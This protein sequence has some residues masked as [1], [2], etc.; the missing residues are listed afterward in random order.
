VILGGGQTKHLIALPLGVSLGNNA[1]A[2]VGGFRLW[3][4]PEWT[5]DTHWREASG[6]I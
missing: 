6:Q 5:R 4:Q 2:I 3:S 1:D